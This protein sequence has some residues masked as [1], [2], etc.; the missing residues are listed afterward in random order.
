MMYVYGCY[1]RYFGMGQQQWA[2]DGCGYAMNGSSKSLF[3]KHN[4]MP[5]PMTQ[6]NV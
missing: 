4:N 3:S 5:F 2:K 6:N 1:G